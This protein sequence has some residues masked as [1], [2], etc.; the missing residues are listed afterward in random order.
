L[1]GSVAGAQW[2]PG[3][4]WRTAPSA[5]DLTSEQ[6]SKI[7]KQTLKSIEEINSKR[8]ELAV[9][10]NELAILLDDPEADWSKIEARLEKV[11]KVRTELVKSELEQR[12]TIWG[13]LSPEQKLSFGYRSGLGLGP[14]SPGLGPYGLGLGLGGGRFGG[15]WMGGGRG[16]NRSW[17]MGR[18]YP[19][20]FAPGVGYRNVR[21]P[22]C[23]RF[24]W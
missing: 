14:C 22:Y 21:R 2:Y 11:N 20:S 15:G 19:G 5:P 1:L 16:F 8:S 7:D 10:Q 18:N 6:L 24:L 4:G 13:H 9:L 12:K 17:Y 23:R 3:M